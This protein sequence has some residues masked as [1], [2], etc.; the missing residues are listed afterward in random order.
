MQSGQSSSV[1]LSQTPHLEEQKAFAFRYH[2]SGDGKMKEP[3]FTD[4][5]RARGGLLEEIKE[6]EYPVVAPEA[7][8]P[9]QN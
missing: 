5:L 2:A 1:S 3:S 7:I 8:L 9:I 4:D 6:N